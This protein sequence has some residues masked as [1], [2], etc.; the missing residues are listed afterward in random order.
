MI[1]NKKEKRVDGRRRSEVGGQ[2]TGR[3]EGEKV[4]GKE[5]EKVRRSEDKKLSVSPMEVQG[6]RLEAERFASNLLPITHNPL[7]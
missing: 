6:W 2:K 5:G 4:R 3:L 1:G 7:P